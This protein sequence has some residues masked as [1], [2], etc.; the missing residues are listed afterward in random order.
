[1]YV[2]NLERA[3]WRNEGWHFDDLRLL[4][5]PARVLLVTERERGPQLTVELV[6]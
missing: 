4:G 2:A 5:L 3:S 1:M 6:T